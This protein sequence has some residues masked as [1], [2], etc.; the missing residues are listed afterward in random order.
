MAL[1]ELEIRRT[2]K[3]M[4]AYVNSRRPPLHVRDEMDLL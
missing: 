2:G 4:A 1:T 3:I